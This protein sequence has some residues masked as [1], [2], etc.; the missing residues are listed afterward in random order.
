MKTHNT[1]ISLLFVIFL[2]I[3]NCLAEPFTTL[4]GSKP[5]VN[6]SYEQALAHNYTRVRDGEQVQKFVKLGLLVRLSGN[7]NYALH[8]VQYPYLRPAGKLLVERLSAQ[9]RKATGEKLVVTSATRTLT[10]APW[11]ASS[12]SVHPAGMAVDFRISQNSKSRAWIENALL[13][14]QSRGVIYATKERNPPHYHVVVLSRQYEAY[15]LRQKA[16]R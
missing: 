6:K 7:E 14:M 16:K 4:K 12:K 13:T 8:E 2:I 3:G 5:K 10:N 11:N 9:Y 1:P 15:V